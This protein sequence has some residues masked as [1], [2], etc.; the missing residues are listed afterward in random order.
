MCFKKLV[1]ILF[2][3]KSDRRGT[4]TPRHNLHINQA[5]VIN[6]CIFESCRCT[7]WSCN[8]II[9]TRGTN[10]LASNTSNHTME[11]T[12]VMRAEPQ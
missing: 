11:R 10:G 3:W 1:I 5:I 9:F 4:R 7:S 2:A 6:C 12:W 8:V